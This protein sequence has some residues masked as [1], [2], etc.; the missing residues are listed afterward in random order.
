MYM[1]SACQFGSLGPGSSGPQSPSPLNI[2]SRIVDS[3]ATAN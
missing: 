3:I 2:V 1:H